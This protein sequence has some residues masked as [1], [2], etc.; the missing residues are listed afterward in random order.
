MALLE[1][2][3]AYAMDAHSEQKR[4][5]RAIHHSSLSRRRNLDRTGDG[6]RNPLSALCMT[7]SKIPE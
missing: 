3:V 6:S 5:W 1:E 7:P 2:A 4:Y